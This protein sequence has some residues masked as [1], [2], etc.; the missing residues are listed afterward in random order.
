MKSAHHHAIYRRELEHWWYRVRREIV[1][2]LIRTH[3]PLDRE[4][5]IADLGSG[6]GAL[7][8]ELERYGRA[9]GVDPSEEASVFARE[10]GVRDMQRGSI[11]QSGLPADSCDLVTCLD[12]LEHIPD[13]RAGVLEIH[14]ILKPGGIGIVFVPAFMF[15]WGKNDED[16][17][18]F[19][20][21][22]LPELEGRFREAGFVIRKRS[23]F[24][25]LLFPAVAAIRMLSRVMPKER[26]KDD[27]EIGGTFANALAYGMFSLERPLL[28]VAA[29]PFGVSAMLVVE[30]PR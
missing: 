2:D 19:R 26:Q 21:Y 12:V 5:T 11:L 10:R 24:N 22:R 14:R 13:D 9:I 15:L 18:H 8:K 1:H 29:F 23:Y 27:V 6:G 16:S 17:E 25:T 7:T 30:K 3:A 28:R 20:R 4:L